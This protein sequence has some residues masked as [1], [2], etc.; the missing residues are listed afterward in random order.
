M[1]KNVYD[2]WD[3]VVIKNNTV[4]WVVSVFEIRAGLFELSEKDMQRLCQMVLY[5]SSGCY[6]SVVYLTFSSNSSIQI[7]GERLTQMISLLF[8][9]MAALRDS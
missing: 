8:A 6:F 4:F 7:V 9:G 2:G 5:Y 3:G 1:S